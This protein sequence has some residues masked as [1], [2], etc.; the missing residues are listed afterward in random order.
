MH[1]GCVYKVTKIPASAMQRIHMLSKLHKCSANNIMF[2][3]NG[4]E[5]DTHGDIISVPL[6]VFG[7]GTLKRYRIFFKT[8]RLLVYS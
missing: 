8:N 3:Q 1:R 4:F 5:T 6:L 7:Y 2:E